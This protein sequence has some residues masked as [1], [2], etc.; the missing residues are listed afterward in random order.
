IPAL[1]PQSGTVRYSAPAGCTRSSTTTRILMAVKSSYPSSLAS[2]AIRSSSLTI[3]T[4]PLLADSVMS[5]TIHS[6]RHRFAARLNSGV[7]PH[8]K[9]VLRSV[10][11]SK[12]PTWTRPASA[13]LATLGI[14]AVAQKLLSLPAGYDYFTWNFFLTVVA[15]AYGTYLFGLYA[16]VGRFTLTRPRASEA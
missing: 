7:R 15:P 4:S 8:N 3:A 6:S 13:I 1:I 12:P 10:F 9:G 5:P 11:N 14:W 16:L 2:R